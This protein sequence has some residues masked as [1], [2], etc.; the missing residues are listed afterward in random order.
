MGAF[1]SRLS[2]GISEGAPSKLRD[3]RSLFQS[4]DSESVSNFPKRGPWRWEEKKFLQKTQSSWPRVATALTAQEFEGLTGERNDR[5]WRQ[6]KI[7][8]GK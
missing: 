2:I 7:E 3:L 5:I 6:N 4:G 1:K 8:S